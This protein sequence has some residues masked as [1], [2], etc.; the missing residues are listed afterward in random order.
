MLKMKKSI[1]FFIICILVLASVN[2]V[3]GDKYFLGSGNG[4]YVLGNPSGGK[5]ILAPAVTPSPTPTITPTSTPSPSPAQSPTEAPTTTPSPTQSPTPA[6]TPT[7]A[8]TPSPSPTEVPTVT[9]TPVETPT[10][11]PSQT[12]VPITP[13]PSPT[14]TPLGPPE[15]LLSNAYY[16]TPS[17]S[18]WQN[19]WPTPP[20]IS[21]KETVSISFI[22]IFS[23]PMYAGKLRLFRDNEQ[24]AESDYE[25]LT[26]ALITPKQ[27]VLQSIY[28]KLP[29]G[30]YKISVKDINNA[31]V[32]NPSGQEYYYNLIVEATSTPT[33]TPSPSP[34]QS[35]T[36]TVTPTPV[37]TPALV[38]GPVRIDGSVRLSNEVK[39][40]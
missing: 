38:F 24:I 33:V 29:P 37:I 15:F 18:T 16:A 17:M 32:K 22:F 27:I 8:E 7:P 39:I 26:T 35:P 14:P 13:S 23:K 40:G 25:E 30:T 9:P 31:P 6:V 11:T 28:Q 12:P 19:M 36:P 34:A 5:Y 3:L 10:V 20:R 4:K 21:E 2:F 1:L